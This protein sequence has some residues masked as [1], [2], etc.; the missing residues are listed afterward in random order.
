MDLKGV[1]DRIN[2]DL[3]SL[4][5]VLECVVND[6][7]RGYNLPRWDPSRHLGKDGGHDGRRLHFLRNLHTKEE[8]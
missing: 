4:D 2:T 1:S 5:W 6:V 3:L 8:R 7:C